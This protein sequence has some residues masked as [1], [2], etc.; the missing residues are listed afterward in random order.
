MALDLYMDTWAELVLSCIC[1]SKVFLVDTKKEC[2]FDWVDIVH[3]G[4]ELLTC[5]KPEA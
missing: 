1:L 4:N 3:E 5:L 2:S